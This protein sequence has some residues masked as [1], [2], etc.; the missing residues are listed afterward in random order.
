MELA[1]AATIWSLWSCWLLAQ[2]VGAPTLL[3]RSAAVLVAAE[4][5]ALAVHSF[6]CD[7]GGCGPAAKTARGAATYD[8]P[9]LAAIF[10]LAAGG[11]A[12]R[13]AARPPAPPPA[14]RVRA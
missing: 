1:A 12:W 9:G 8:V 7:P 5:L 3:T 2:H 6:G 13:R 4:I 10:V 14:R 11:Y